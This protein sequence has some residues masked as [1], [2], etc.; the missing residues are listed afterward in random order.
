MQA[1]FKW[2]ENSHNEIKIQGYSLILLAWGEGKEG[3]V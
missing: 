1:T 3:G 2:F